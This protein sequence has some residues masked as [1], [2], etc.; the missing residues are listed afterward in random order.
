MAKKSKELSEEDK[1]T[2]VPKKGAKGKKVALAS[3]PSSEETEDSKPVSVQEVTQPATEVMVTAEEEPIQ[4]ESAPI[5][6][7]TPLEGEEQVTEEEEQVAIDL[8]GLSKVQLL[9][10]FKEKLAH[11][12]SL[13]LDKIVHEIKLV[14]DELTQ[15]DRDEALQRYLAEGGAADDFS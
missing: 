12:I 9:D 7:A 14:Y 8:S 11:G 4:E 6:V 10:L 15:K 2:S 13:K 1:V 5:L 3:I